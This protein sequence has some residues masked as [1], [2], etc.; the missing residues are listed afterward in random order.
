[1]SKN[2]NDLDR[3]WRVS[4][5][6]ILKINSRSHCSLLPGLMSSPPPSNQIKIRVFS[7]YRKGFLSKDKFISSFFENCLLNEDSIMFRNIRKLSNELKL[8]RYELHLAGKNEVK[9]SS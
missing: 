7:F 4:C 9:S 8:S 6:K 2:Q 3:T 1:M 5:R